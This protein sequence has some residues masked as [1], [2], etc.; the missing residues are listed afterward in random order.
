MT[1]VIAT[2]FTKMAGTAKESGRAYDMAQLHILLPNNEIQTAAC[3]K[4]G[5]G[6]VGTEY[7]V[8]PTAAHRFLSL[9]FTDR[10]Y[11]LE[12]EK[13]TEL[14]AGRN[15]AE[16]FTKCIGFRIVGV[17]PIRFTAPEKSSSSVPSPASEPKA[18]TA[19]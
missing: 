2:G 9:D 14:R 16:E 3:M 17:L 11:M 19:S 7:P 12:L 13:R 10:L 1:T 4:L 15:G 5:T 18:S 6:Q 8:D